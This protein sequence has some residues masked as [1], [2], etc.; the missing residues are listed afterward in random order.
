MLVLQEV[1]KVEFPGI[2]LSKPCEELCKLVPAW[3]EM[4]IMLQDM[5][6]A[7]RQVPGAPEH[8][9]YMIVA[10]YVP[11][12]GW[13]YI[14][15]FGCP[16]GMASAVLNFNRLPTLIS[17]TLRRCFGVAA[18]AYFDDNCAV[19]VASAAGTAQ[20]AITSV[21]SWTGA[22]LNEAKGMPPASRRV[23]LGLDTDLGPAA[24][25]GNCSQDLKP[26]AR[27]DIT[28]TSTIS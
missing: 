9:K 18:A 5:A 19:D 16:F 24:R 22:H 1:L 10:V 4:Q 13:R 23:F 21:F 6:D 26:F 11:G 3:A 15:M 14:K 20:N 25:L 12:T 7:Y 8:A 28:S 2:D 27:V 17:A